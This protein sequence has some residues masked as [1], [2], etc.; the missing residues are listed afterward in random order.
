MKILLS[1]GNI[2]F[3]HSSYCKYEEKKATRPLH[4]G[5]RDWQ[6]LPQ[7]PAAPLLG[8]NSPVTVKSEVQAAPL[9]I[10]TAP[11]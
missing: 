3:F 10:Q 8:I 11:K 9:Q 6:H 7:S 1:D 5:S 2:V 4:H